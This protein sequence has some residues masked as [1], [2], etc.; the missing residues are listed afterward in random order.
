MDVIF[1]L[2]GSAKSFK[3]CAKLFEAFA[4]QDLPF[5]LVKVMATP[6][7]D[8]VVPHQA[9]FFATKDEMVA[10]SVTYRTEDVRENGLDVLFVDMFEWDLGINYIPPVQVH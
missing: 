8:C 7:R 4:A 6:R 5:M 3:H 2:H 1:Q 10:R 9:M